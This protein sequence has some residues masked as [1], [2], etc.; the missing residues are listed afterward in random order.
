MTHRYLILDGEIGGTGLRDQF[1]GFI[2]I[3]DVPISSL[4]KLEIILWLENYHKNFY[5]KIKIEIEVI[6]ELDFKG[7][8]IMN[9][10]QNELGHEYKIRYY[11]DIK[12]KELKAL[13]N[14][15]ILVI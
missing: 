3:D 15:Q 11:S 1:E 7:I 12:C 14:G 8:E 5:N 6:P 9:K 13:E 4:L 10:I 2:Q